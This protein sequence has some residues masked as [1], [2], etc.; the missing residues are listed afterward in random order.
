[1]AHSASKSDCIFCK[2]VAGEIPSAKLY[3]DEHVLAFMDINPL[4]EGHVLVIPKVHY[5]TLDE[6]SADD[7]AALTRC[8]PGLVRAVR[9][10][11]HAD[12][13]NVL[14]NN[15]RV[16]GQVVMHVHIHLIPRVPGD[17]LGYR[18]PAGKYAE[19]RLDAVREM[20]AKEI[21]KNSE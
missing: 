4:A 17:G 16:S 10:A 15:G 19:G 1:M 6:M 11:V 14:Q 7:V 8:L 9:S 3:E 21:A 5:E 18:W 12:G 20:I 2:I 13:L